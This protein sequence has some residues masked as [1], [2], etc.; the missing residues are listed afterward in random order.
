VYEAVYRS[1]SREL[2]TLAQCKGAAPEAALA[3][4]AQLVQES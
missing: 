1:L 4:I 3:A 2:V